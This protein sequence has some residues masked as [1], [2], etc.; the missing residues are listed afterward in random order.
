MVKLCNIFQYILLFL[1]RIIIFVSIHPDKSNNL[2]NE[3]VL[4]FMNRNFTKNVNLCNP[5]PSYTSVAILVGI[6]NC[7]LVQIVSFLYDE[8]K[9]KS[10]E[11]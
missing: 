8:F 6:I 4:T 5:P 7:N 9:Q 2:H 1:Y 10:Q 3:K 11:L